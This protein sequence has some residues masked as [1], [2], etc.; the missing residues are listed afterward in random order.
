MKA[1]LI[2]AL[3]AIAACNCLQAQ[4][5]Y[6]YAVV[7]HDY[8]L[9]VVSKGVKDTAQQ[10][11]NAIPNAETVKKIEEMR[12]NGWEVFDTEVTHDAN[13]NRPI[14]TFYLRRKIKN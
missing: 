2:T 9:V 8:K 11:G 12:K 13:M 3:L 5:K 1:P 4:V 10:S 14:H 6:E 7:E